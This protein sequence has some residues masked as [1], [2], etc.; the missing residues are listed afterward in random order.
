MRSAGHAGLC[1]V[2][3]EATPDHSRN[4]ILPW[5]CVSDMILAVHVM[6]SNHVKRFN[7]SQV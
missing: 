2:M 5:S 3:A 7:A 4:Q 6:V 1:S